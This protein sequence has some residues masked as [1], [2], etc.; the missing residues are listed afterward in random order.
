MMLAAAAPMTV[1]ATLSREPSAAAVMAA[2]APPTIWVTDRSRPLEVSALI[3]ELMWLGEG[4]GSEFTG[5]T[6]GANAAEAG[7]VTRRV[8]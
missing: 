1:P 8:G 3:S 6:T 5:I 2:N 4:L 7:I